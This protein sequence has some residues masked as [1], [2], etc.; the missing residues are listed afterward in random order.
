M[1]LVAISAEG[2]RHAR[3]RALALLSRIAGIGRGATVVM[4][5]AA[6]FAEDEPE[7]V[8]E[9]HLVMVP[10]TRFLK[11]GLAEDGILDVHL[12]RDAAKEIPSNSVIVID[13]AEHRLVIIEQFLK[14][15][16]HAWHPLEIWPRA[17]AL[18]CEEA[19]LLKVAPLLSGAFYCQPQILT[20][21]E[22][23]RVV[24]RLE[25]DARI[26]RWL[27]H[28]AGLFQQRVTKIVKKFGNRSN[29]R[30]DKKEDRQR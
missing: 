4:D 5:G 2:M 14:E 17:F 28:N 7:S 19:Q 10:I 8:D 12:L 22:V 16:R 1:E 20:P 25:K 18:V 21:R 11:E 26:Y 27:G 23:V 13:A 30:A 9:A 3:S 15:A 24:R 6:I 29:A